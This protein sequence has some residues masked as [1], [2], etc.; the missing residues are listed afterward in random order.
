MTTSTGKSFDIS[1]Q[2]VWDAFRQVRK[3]KGAPGGDAVSLAEFEEDLGNNLYKIWNRLCSGSYFPPPVKAVHIRQAWRWSS[4]AGGSDGR[5][6]DRPDRG[7]Q[8]PRVAG[9]A[10]FPCGLVWVAAEPVGVAGGRGDPAAVLGTAVGG[11]SGRPGV[12]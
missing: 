7:R 2:Q 5:R 8:S 11:R 12:L 3:N 4:G 1:K 6:S 9:G 10:D